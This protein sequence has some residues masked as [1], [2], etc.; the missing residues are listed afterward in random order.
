MVG[1]EN[2]DLPSHRPYTF[3]YLPRGVNLS[4]RFDIVGNDENLPL[5]VASV[6]GNRRAPRRPL[7]TGNE[8]VVV[9]AP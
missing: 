8:E 7:H 6:E 5:H 2:G 1:G 4:P 9:I 3:I